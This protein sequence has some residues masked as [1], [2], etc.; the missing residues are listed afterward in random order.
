MTSSQFP[1]FRPRN[2]E[3]LCPGCGQQSA[4][5]LPFCT[6]CAHFVADE[7]ALLA[8]PGNTKTQFNLPDYLVG[9]DPRGNDYDRDHPG[10]GLVWAGLPLIAVPAL[11]SNLS[12]VSIVAW[13]GG[14]VIV[15]VGTVKARGDSQSM[16]RSGIATGLAGALTV[17]IIVNQI[18][19]TSA[20]VEPAEVASVVAEQTESD[21]AE[22]ETPGVLMELTGTVPVIRGSPEHSGILPGPELE[23][24][25]YRSWRYDTGLNL[26]S[27]PVIAD[28]SAYVGTQDGNLVS[29]DLM[30]GLQRWSKP[31]GNAGY[32]VAAAPAV[33]DQNVYVGSGYSIYAF[34]RE[35]GTMKWTFDDGGALAYTGESSPNVLD[36]VVYV[37]SKENTIYALDTETGEK[38]W[39]YKTNGL[40]FGSPAV[41]GDYVVVG[42]DDGNIF[43]LNRETGFLAW[44]YQAEGGVFSS[45]AISG[46]SVVLTLASR[47]V[48]QLGLEDGVLRWEHPIGGDASPAVT[49]DMVY[50]GSADGGVYALAPD[51][52]EQDEWVFPTGS[53]T[54]LSPVVVEDTVYAAAG[55]TLYAIDRESGEKLWHYPIG[56]EVS[57]EPVVVDGVIYIGARNGNLYAIA[58]DAVFTEQADS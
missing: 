29:I 49:K 3:K 15:L 17:A 47:T 20:S 36:G 31:I 56:D 35:R 25:P 44:K 14:L 7:P 16:M 24:N 48:I 45:P 12:P 33:D 30:T 51:A 28:G 13:A 18:I 21:E 57:T 43:A 26:K 8:G 52:G 2:A 46:D 32:P 53:D 1:S 40:I 23:G 37:A 42:V 34:D 41:S 39:R 5:S 38:L 58:G 19:S 27:T 50:V 22:E 9:D 4:A 6:H 10:T 54:V 55:S 11:T